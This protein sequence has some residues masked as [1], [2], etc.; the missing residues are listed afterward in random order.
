M[1]TKPLGIAHPVTH[2][3]IASQNSTVSSLGRKLDGAAS[4]SVKPSF[5]KRG[6]TSVRNENYYRMLERFRGALPQPA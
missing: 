2:T 5:S 6:F 4:S 1:F 3:P